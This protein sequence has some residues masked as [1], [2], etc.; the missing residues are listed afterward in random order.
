MS[1]NVRAA[2]EE[3]LPRL[4]SGATKTRIHP[5]VAQNSQAEFC[6]IDAC[7]LLRYIQ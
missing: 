6:A 1:T 5:P 7:V 2:L 3:I 4:K